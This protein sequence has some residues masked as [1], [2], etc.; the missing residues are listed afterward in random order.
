MVLEIPTS[1]YAVTSKSSTYNTM[2]ILDELSFLAKTHGSHMQAVNP[3][4]MVP[5]QLQGDCLVRT[6]SSLACRHMV[7]RSGLVF[8]NRPVVLLIPL[9]SSY[10]EEM[11]AAHQAESH[12]SRS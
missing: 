3:S 8:L 1:D 4:V 11:L 9:P 6:S 7:V 10:P 2:N 12:S 5:C